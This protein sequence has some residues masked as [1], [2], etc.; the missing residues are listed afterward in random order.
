[1]RLPYLF[2]HFFLF[3]QLFEKC[4]KYIVKVFFIICEPFEGTLFKELLEIRFSDVTCIFFLTI[5]PDVFPSQNLVSMLVVP[6]TFLF[7]SQTLSGLLN[8]LEF[9]SSV[10]FTIFVRMPF[11][12]CFLICFFNCFSIS[13]PINIK[14]FVVTRF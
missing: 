12:R 9:F 5:I 8:F 10:N 6:C 3:I 7:I 2:F 4:P 1:M 13:F 14:N 11:K